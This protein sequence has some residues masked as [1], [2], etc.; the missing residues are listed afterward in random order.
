[1]FVVTLSGSD[2]QL[3]IT[4]SFCLGFENHFDKINSLV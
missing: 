3:M 4:H 1:M 2:D